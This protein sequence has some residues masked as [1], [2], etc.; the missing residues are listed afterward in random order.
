MFLRYRFW[1]IY[2]NNCPLIPTEVEIQKLV[3]QTVACETSNIK[4]SKKLLNIFKNHF[5]EHKVKE[6][7]NIKSRE[8]FYKNLKQTK[9]L[10]EQVSCY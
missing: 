1:I 8:N 7:I 10:H 3:R 9:Y 2:I 5:T 4:K 6:Y